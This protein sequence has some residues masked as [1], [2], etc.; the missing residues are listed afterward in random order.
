MSLPTIAV[1]EFAP[2]PIAGPYSKYLGGDEL[3][4]LIAILEAAAPKVMVEFGCNEGMTAKRIL[5]HVHSI[6]RYIG[7]DVKRGT[8]QRSPTS[9]T[10]C[11]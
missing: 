8:V 7:I 6:E 11:L 5:Q 2:K 9:A 10:K 3:K 1:A 4:V